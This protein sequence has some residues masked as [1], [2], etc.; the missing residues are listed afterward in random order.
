[1]AFY[2]IDDRTIVQTSH[3]QLPVLP[4]RREPKRQE[5][6]Q[7][8]RR[9]LRKKFGVRTE[10]EVDE[11]VAMPGFPTPMKRTNGRDEPTAFWFEDQ[12]DRFRQHEVAR[13][14]RTLELLG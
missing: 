12:L 8:L 14:S 10:A 13:A 5:N 3:E 1:M 4:D 9:D 6:R 7:L 2:K 11:I